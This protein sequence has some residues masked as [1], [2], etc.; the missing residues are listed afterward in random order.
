MVAAHEGALAPVPSA[1]TGLLYVGIGTSTFWLAL[2][3]SPVGARGLD[4]ATRGPREGAL[5]PRGQ[6]GVVELDDR[7][8]PLDV[9]GGRK[10]AERRRGAIR[11]MRPPMNLEHTWT[12]DFYGEMGDLRARFRSCAR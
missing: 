8:P 5:G 10:A 11:A 3:L 12:H 1:P 9:G 7:S 2:A 4:S 6:R